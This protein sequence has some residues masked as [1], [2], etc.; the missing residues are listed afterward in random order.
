[1]KKL[2]S[3]LT[4]IFFLTSCSK[5]DVQ[6]VLDN[7]NITFGFQIAGVPVVLSLGNGGTGLY[8]PQSG[9][10]SYIYGGNST[11]MTAC[12]VVS[13]PVNSES[14]PVFDQRG[15]PIGTVRCDQG[16]GSNT[17]QIFLSLKNWFVQHPGTPCIVLVR[18]DPRPFTN[19][20]WEGTIV[21]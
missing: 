19:G 14:V 9:Y 15:L 17:N 7:S 21:G 2:L 5:E 10:S 12:Y 20:R 3:I 6:N 1:M 13:S 11:N 8:Y 16:V 4:A 18:W